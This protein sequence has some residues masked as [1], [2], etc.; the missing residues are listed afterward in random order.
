MYALLYDSRDVSPECSI[1]ERVFTVYIFQ[2]DSQCPII[3][4][5]ILYELNKQEDVRVR[6]NDGEPFTRDSFNIGSQF[7]LVHI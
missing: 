7:Y 1:D 3:D 5:D 2:G 4:E 6:F